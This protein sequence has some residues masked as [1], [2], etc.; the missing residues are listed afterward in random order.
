MGVIVEQQVP[1]RISGVLFTR[2]PDGLAHAAP[3]DLVI[4][5]CAGLGDGLVS[6]RVDPHRLVVSRTTLTVQTRHRPPRGAPATKV[7]H[8]SHRKRSGSCRGSPSRLKPA[9]GA[10]QDIEWAID[11]D[12]V[13]WILQAP[14]DHDFDAAAAA[15]AG[16]VRPM[17]CGRTRTSTRTSRDRFRRCSIRSRRLVTTTTSAISGLAF[18]VSRR[19]L[20]A[21]DR[22]LAGIIG[23]HGARMYYNL[24][25][26]HAVL[27]MAPFGERLAAAFNQFV[28][29]DETAAQP[30]DAASLAMS[31]V[32]PAAGDGAPANRCADHLAVPVPW[33]SSALVRAHCRSVRR[34]R[35]AANA[36]NAERSA[37]WSTI[38]TSFWAFDAI[39]GRTHRSPIPRQWCVMRSSSG[40]CR[41]KAAKAAPHCTTACCAG[42]PACRRAFR[43]CGSGRFPEPSDRTFRCA[44]S[45]TA[46]LR[47]F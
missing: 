28:G 27:R 43:R 24:T 18:G 7:P 12:G 23:V 5:Y 22:R 9:L 13:I 38:S 8:S 20:R 33:Q 1:A 11:Q 4:E 45:L 10:P 32:P 36:S 41:A 34:T 21:M 26:I 40:R 29:V 46:T 14:S 30:A 6:G 19:R 16:L 39:A 37:H 17:C 42:C 44:D 31:T 2:A 47:T 15:A 25:N 3:D 35:G